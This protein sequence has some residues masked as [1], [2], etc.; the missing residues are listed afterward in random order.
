M[1]VITKHLVAYTKHITTF[2][3]SCYSCLHWIIKEKKI[4]KINCLVFARWNFYN[5]QLFFSPHW[6]FVYGASNIAIGQNVTTERWTKLN[7]Q[8]MCDLMSNDIVQESSRLKCQMEFVRTDVDKSHDRSANKH[9]VITEAVHSIW[10]I[11]AAKCLN[12]S[13]TNLT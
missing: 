11:W 12:N 5:S 7:Y 10:N 4:G 2:Q 6:Q 1:L 3:E 8:S 9:I 13:R